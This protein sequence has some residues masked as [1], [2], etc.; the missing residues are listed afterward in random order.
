MTPCKLAAALGIRPQVPTLALISADGELNM[1]AAAEGLA[2]DDP[3]VH[4]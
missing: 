3:N 2:V 1:V 4:P